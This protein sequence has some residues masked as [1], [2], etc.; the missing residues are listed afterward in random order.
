TNRNDKQSYKNEFYRDKN[1]ENYQS[2]T[3][4]DT[5]PA[6][7]MNRL[8]SGVLISVLYN[9]ENQRKKGLEEV[10][11]DMQRKHREQNKSGG[12]SR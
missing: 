8:F 6:E 1:M 2:V 4:A 3:Y 9:N 11:W 10:E 12:L 7:Y 5:S